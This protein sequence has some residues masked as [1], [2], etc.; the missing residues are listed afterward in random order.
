MGTS[1]KQINKN[2]WLTW[3]YILSKV[4]DNKTSVE[5]LELTLFPVT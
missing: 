2:K 1:K 3:T 4:G 5:P